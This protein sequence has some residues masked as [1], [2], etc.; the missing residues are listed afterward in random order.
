MFNNHI[1][2]LT[3]M[4]DNTDID[5]FHHHRKFYW[6]HCL[7]QFEKEEI[8]RWCKAGQSKAT[9]TREADACWKHVETQHAETTILVWVHTQRP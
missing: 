7:R 2:F 8:P 4:L 6:T 1:C 3:I 9:A 5:Y